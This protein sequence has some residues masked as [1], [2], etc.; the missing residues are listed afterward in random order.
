MLKRIEWD[1][2]GDLRYVIQV[3]PKDDD[4]EEDYSYLAR[5]SDDPESAIRYAKELLDMDGEIAADVYDTELDEFI[6]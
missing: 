1:G 5:T 6:Y 3:G 4:S 2:K